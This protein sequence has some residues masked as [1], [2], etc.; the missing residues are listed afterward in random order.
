M[1]RVAAG[2]LRDGQGRILLSQRPEGKH[3]AGTWEFPGG[4]CQPDE[5]PADA[6]DREFAE[7]LGIEVA[8]AAPLLSLTHAY[9]EKSV[10]LLLYEVSK[11]AGEPRGCEGQALKWA[12]PA[13]L[14]ALEMPAADRPIVKVLNLDPRYAITPDP[15]GLGG[16]DNLLAR[17]ERSLQAGA[18]LLQLRAHSLLA[19]D[20]S[21][22]AA[23][24]AALAARYGARWLLNGPPEI[25]LQAGADGVHLT[26]SKLMALDARPLPG[27]RLVAASCHDAGELVQAGR[28]GADFVTLSPVAQTASHPQ[29]RA[30]GWQRFALLC[31][32]SPLPVYAL[33]GV[34][35]AELPVVRDHGGFGVAGIRGFTGS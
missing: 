33:G 29:A 35:P 3:L 10:R 31:A 26:A 14:D 1:I 13:E 6:L 24:F 11:F 17:A 19:G 30:L 21:D 8:A 12:A 2:V 5:S 22:L 9:P 15:A 16:A 34:A 20:L 4:K 32:Q 7:E 18:R 28:I 25:A 27:D 23:R